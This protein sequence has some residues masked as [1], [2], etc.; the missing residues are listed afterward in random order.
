MP[1]I[2]D[3][4]A[5]TLQLIAKD[6]LKTAIQHLQQLLQS[7][8]LL[9]EVIGQSARL[10]DLM[11]QIRRGTIELESANIEKNLIRYSLMDLLREIE[12]QSANNATL[13]KE[14]EEVLIAQTLTKNNNAIISGSH[15]IMIQDG[16]GIINIKH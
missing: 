12:E 6:D 15:N 16:Y 2:P 1:N 7:S 10:T 9:D 8:P 14:V 13:K 11:Q 5:A 4:V 3:F